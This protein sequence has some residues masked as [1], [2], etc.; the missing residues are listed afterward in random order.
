MTI[1]GWTTPVMPGLDPGIHPGELGCF[2][3]P[4]QRSEVEGIR[5]RRARPRPMDPR[6]KPEDDE[7]GRTRGSDL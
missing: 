1:A 7:A 6:F 2:G 3:V 5:L 4:H